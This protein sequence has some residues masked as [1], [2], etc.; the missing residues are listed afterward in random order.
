MSISVPSE[1]MDAMA[2]CVVGQLSLGA[3][4]ERLSNSWNESVMLRKGR[5]VM[6]K[7]HLSRIMNESRNGSNVIPRSGGNA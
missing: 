3:R 5:I 7:I 1:K 2:Q 6:H 4:R